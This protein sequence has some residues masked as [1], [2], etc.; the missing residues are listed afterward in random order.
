ML[1]MDPVHQRR[2]RHDEPAAA[3]RSFRDRRRRRDRSRS[4]PLRALRADPDEPAQQLHHRPDLRHRDPEGTPRRLPRRDRAGDSAHHRRDQTA[5]PRRGRR[6]RPRHRR[7][8]RHGRRY[9]EPAVP[10]SDARVPLGPRTRQRALRPSDAGA[11]HPGGRRTQ[12]QADAAQRQGTDRPRHS[13]GH[14]A[15]PH[16]IGRWTRRSRPRSRTSATSRRTAS[17]RRATCE[18]IYEVPLRF[19][20]EGF[21]QRVV[22]KLNI[23]T[24]AAQPRQ[25]AADRQDRAESQDHGQRRGGRQVRQP[26]RFVQEPARGDRARRDRQRGAGR[27]R[28]RRCRRA[29]KGQR[30]RAAGG[31]PHAIIIPGGFGERGIEGKIR[32]VRYA[33]ENR[34]ADSRNLPTAC[35]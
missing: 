35:R 22:E 23:W 6:F 20:D 15:L 1:K 28:L 34:R 8:R 4:R 16:A 19:H 29:G 33:R 21:D 11:V 12:D 17:S 18:S 7:D 9:R 32:A 27:Y 26:G 25:V 5:H 24:G 13:A 10:R 30:R 31:R 3:R 2:S 14:P